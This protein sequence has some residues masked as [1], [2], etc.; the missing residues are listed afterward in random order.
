MSVGD[1]AASQAA[2]A[3]FV[4]RGEDGRTTLRDQRNELL[5]ALAVNRDELTR[6]ES[7]IRS[8]PQDDATASL[9]DRLRLLHAD[10]DESED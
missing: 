6:L 10:L 4:E 7:G 5:V 2:W 1:E 8:L 9:L 3:V